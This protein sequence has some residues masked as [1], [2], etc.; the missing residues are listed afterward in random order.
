MLL[1]ELLV[2]T[3]SRFSGIR[4]PTG[5]RRVAETDVDLSVILDLGKLLRGVVCNECQS[6]I[7]GLEGL[8]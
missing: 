2:P 4:S 3:N 7:G 5:A 1:D 6:D 8:R